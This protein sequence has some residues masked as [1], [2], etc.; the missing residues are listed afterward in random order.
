MDTLADHMLGSESVS[1]LLVF[2]KKNE[3]RIRARMPVGEG[4][5]TKHLST[6]SE[7]IK[8]HTKG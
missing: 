6:T 3:S 2:D 5:G 1:S 4:F 8:G 7:D